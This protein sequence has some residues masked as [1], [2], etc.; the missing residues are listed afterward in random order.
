MYIPEHRIQD[1]V[2]PNETFRTTCKNCHALARR[3]P[4]SAPKKTGSCSPTC[5]LPSSRRPKQRSGEWAALR[6][7]R[8]H[9][10]AGAA[11]SGS[12]GNGSREWRGRGPAGR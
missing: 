12:P 7:A 2:I 5:T 1:E 4:G 3:C 6:E 9:R 11:R 8:E 10:V